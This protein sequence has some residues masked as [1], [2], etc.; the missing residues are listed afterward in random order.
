MLAKAA[1]E[2]AERKRDVFRE[3]RTLKNYVVVG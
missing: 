1:L 3:K 2:I